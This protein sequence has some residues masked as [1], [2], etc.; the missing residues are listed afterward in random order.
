MKLK[1][2]HPETHSKITKT[3]QTRTRST[4][5]LLLVLHL[6]K[7]KR[8]LGCYEDPMWDKFHKK[9][10]L[11]FQARRTTHKQTY[12]MWHIDTSHAVGGQEHSPIESRYFS[13]FFVLSVKVLVLSQRQELVPIAVKDTNI[14][15]LPIR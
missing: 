15:R 5:I 4:E 10:N 8:I 14:V 2:T 7:E 12:I 6:G 13:D 9:N 3:Q 11:V 1:G